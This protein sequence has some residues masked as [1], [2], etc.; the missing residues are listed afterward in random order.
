[1]VAHI[2]LFKPKASLSAAQR[3]AFVTAFEYALT[4][5]PSIRRARVGTRLRLGRPY[6]AQPAADFPFIALLEFDSEADLRQYLDHPAHEALGQQFYV[7]ADAALV[8]DFA[9]REGDRARDLLA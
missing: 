3:E 4:N 1:M 8:F 6:D 7:T 5:I 2:V 9:L